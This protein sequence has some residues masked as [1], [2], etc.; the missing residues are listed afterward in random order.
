MRPTRAVRVRALAAGSISEAGLSVSVS[1]RFALVY[2]L[3]RGSVQ[4]LNLAGG[5]LRTVPV[6][7]AGSLLAAAW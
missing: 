3:R 5:Q 4:E 7:A 2:L 6:A 1:G